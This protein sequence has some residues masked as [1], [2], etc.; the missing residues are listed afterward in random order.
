MSSC[1]ETSRSGLV[2][3]AL[4]A[5]ALSSGCYEHHLCGEPEVCNYVD[6]DCDH[7]VDEDFVD[8]D[9]VYSTLEHCGG[10]GVAC[11]EVFPTAAATECVVA[12][13]EATCRIVACPEG[14]H[15][16]GD[17]ACV[18]DV[19]IL[20][21][22]CT[23]DADCELRLPG[24]RCRELPS[25][26]RRCLP[27]CGEGP[28]PPGFLCDDGL[29]APVTGDCSCTAETLGAELACLIETPGHACAGIRVCGESGFEPCEPALAEV[30]N[31]VDEDCDGA[32]D[33]DFRNED[34]LYVDRLHCGAC[35]RPCVEPG[36]NML[37]TCEARGA[38]RVRCVIECLE[39]FVDVDGLTVNGCEC[40]R[41]DGTGPPPAVGGDADCDGVPDDTDDFVYVTTTGN[42]DDPGTLER[43]MRTIRAALERGRRQGKDVLVARGVYDGGLDVVGGVSVFGGYRPDFRD[44]D[45]TLYPVVVERRGAGPGAAVLTCRGVTEPTRVEGFT[46]QGTDAV[47]PG[48][49]STAVYLDRCGAD[50]VLAQ[51]TVLA[52]RGADGVRGDSSSDNLAD[53]G[54]SSLGE[55]AGVDGTDGRAPGGGPFCERVPSGVGGR[56]SCPGGDVSG[57][58]GGDAACPDSGCVN[59]RPCGNGG[60]TD[61]TVGGVCDFRAVLRAAVPNPA[62]QAGRG[63]EPGAAG[64]LTYNSPTN[65][66]VCNFCDDNPTLQRNGGIGGDGA[67]GADGAGGNGCGGGPQLDLA[68]GRI[69]GGGGT[70]GSDGTNGSGG[71]GGTAGSGYEVIGATMG[72]CD[73]RSGGS[74]GGG[75]SGGCGAPG[76]DGGTGGGTSAG[77]VIRLDGRARGPA[78]EDVRVVTASGGSGGDGGVGAA[79][80]GAGSGGVGGRPTFWCART[81][82]RGGDGGGGGSGGGGGGGCGGGSHGVLVAAG[83]GSPMAYAAELEAA[84]A[85]DRTGVAGRGGEGG[86]SPG[87]SG[88]DGLD[89]RSD[90]IRV[91]P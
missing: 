84:L 75:G 90:A 74:G 34:G 49:G 55:L 16:G 23:E 28:C 70:D 57:G 50:V 48:E 43:P 77:I 89:G 78:L 31:A 9:G 68:S 56:K 65:R 7:E 42:D 91:L 61:F 47:R 86:F 37:A 20:C 32:V 52:G 66:G 3:A 53:V 11:P 59:G 14:F 81:G 1:V 62:A 13:G 36:P 19:P 79:G 72:G 30:C 12:D 18:P 87:A 25:G 54:L 45:L 67:R 69:T 80:G 29:C 21:L 63:A 26:S 46:V 27:D 17:G 73:D 5:S 33:E 71:G 35:A 83:G 24:A 4:L 60:C 44:R 40:E 10:C 85:I 41:F 88:T 76:A 64:P 51:I 2:A 39:G 6:D 15:L 82:G 8:D 38:T 58:R 22:P